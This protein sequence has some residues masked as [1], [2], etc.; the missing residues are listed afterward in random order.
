MNQKLFDRSMEI[1]QT[2]LQESKFDEHSV[3]EIVLV[4]GSTRIPKVQ[5]MIQELFDGKAP[6]RTV[7]PDEAVAFGAAVLAATLSDDEKALR[8]D[9]PVL[10]DVTPLSV[11]LE[12]SGG[13]MNTLIERNSTIP[14]K[15]T[16]VYTTVANNQT[17][18]LIQV[19]QGER[20]ITA[21]NDF[22]GKF[23][24]S[25]P[26]Q[27]QGAAK[28]A[29]T[30]EI[31]A[32]GIL[33]VSANDDTGISNSITITSEKGRLTQDDINRMIKEAEQFKVDDDTNKQR[34]DVRNRVEKLCLDL[35]N[36][37]AAG[38]LKQ[39]FGTYDAEQGVQDT[40]DWL[41]KNQLADKC[42]FDATLVALQGIVKAE[43]CPKR[44]RTS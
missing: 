6:C 14:A 38:N 16:Q 19:F 35:R 21:D 5:S 25:I 27:S 26:R 9:A 39:K 3:H 40:M 18:V 30:F 4:G 42:D 15:K 13:V 7:N 1:M 31:D 29:V 32:T 37:I 20:A 24:L 28:I 34:I 33:S 8:V 10:L 41:D 23:E 44:P 2:C 17:S 36:A 43:P 11:G 12:T 22:L